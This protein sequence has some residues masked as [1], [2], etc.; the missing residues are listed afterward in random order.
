MQGPWRFALACALLAM[1]ASARAAEP[2][3]H[4]AWQMNIDCGYVAT[5]TSFLEL[6]QD[7]ASQA[8]TARLTDCGTVEVPGAI[9]RLVLC[10]TDPA[11]FTGSILDGALRLPET[12]RW[13]SYATGAHE[14]NVPGACNAARSIEVE[15]VFTGGVV[16]ETDGR[17]TVLA[18]TFQF[19]KIVLRRSNGALC[20]ALDSAQTCSVDLRRNDLPVGINVT[21]V[22]RAGASVTFE[23]VLAP[24]TVVVMPLTEASAD[25]PARFAV[26]GNDNVRVY[27]DVHTTARVA[28]VITTCF[29][30]PDAND[31]GLV[32]GASPPLDEDDLVVLHSE[33]GAFI[34]RTDRVDTIRKEVCARTTS[35]SQLTVASPSAP[36]G[37]DDPH[38]AYQFRMDRGRRGRERL[39]LTTGLTLTSSVTP[40]EIDPGRTGAVLEVFSATEGSPARFELKAAGWT[41]SRNRKRARFSGRAGPGNRPVSATIG[42]VGVWVNAHVTTA[43]VGLPLAAPQTAIAWRLSIG[44]RRWCAA[45][46]DGYKNARPVKDNRAGHYR[47]GLGHRADYAPIAD[48]DDKRI[49]WLFR[50]VVG[51]D[52]R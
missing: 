42:P 7:S 16:D 40:G 22:P 13:V 52:Q 5:A 3:V 50:R 38:V 12:G 48:C 20:F 43:S 28:G 21:A 31:D 51:A 29:A 10:H 15:N 27:Y 17:A 11:T 47:A 18:G 4:G 41:V 23:Q 49:S 25:V 32:D 36:G 30:Y 24:G 46:V 26:I 44:D 9:S 33:D 14:V 8:F 39:D 6:G 19:S 1:T 45:A 34:D 2:D 35:L 37:I